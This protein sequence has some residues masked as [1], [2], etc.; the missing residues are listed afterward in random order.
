MLNSTF[1]VDKKDFRNPIGDKARSTFGNPYLSDK[2]SRKEYAKEYTLE[3]KGKDAPSP[4]KYNGDL[5]KDKFISSFYG[6]NQEESKQISR[7]IRDFDSMY[8]NK[9]QKSVRNIGPSQYQGPQFM[10][11]TSSTS[12]LKPTTSYFGSKAFRHIDVRTYSQLN[13]KS[14]EKGLH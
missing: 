3:M 10:K 7:E 1:L 13:H 2:F 8:M 12:V 11:M 4:E 6:G 9:H 5:I 14:I